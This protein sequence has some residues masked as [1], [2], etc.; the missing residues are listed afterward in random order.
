MPIHASLCFFGKFKSDF[1]YETTKMILENE[2]VDGI[3][4]ASDL[5]ALGSMRAV[6]EKGSKVPED[7]KIIGF[8]DIYVSQY[9]N[10]PLT[11]IRQPIYQIGYQASKALIEFIESDTKTNDQRLI[12]L[13]VELIERSST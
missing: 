6:H 9:L 1:G 7:I 13:D 4:C 11:T 10:P 5:I 2:A 8:D 3:F 12:I